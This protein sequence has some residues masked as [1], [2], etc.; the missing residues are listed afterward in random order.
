GIG[1]FIK[2]SVQ[3]NVEVGDPT[4][5]AVRVDGR[6]VRA[7]VIGEGA[8]LGCTQAGRIEYALS[9]GGATGGSINTDFIDN[10]AGAA[11]P[12]HEVN[13]KIALAAA[14]RAGRLTEPARIKL[15][16]AMTEEVA[17]DVLENNRL[18]A[19]ALSIAEARGPTAIG[20][21]LRLIETLEESGQLDRKTEGL[22]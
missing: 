10:S 13:I 5:D 22:A 19:L 9:G 6:A 4:N 2:S 12:A 11:C 8:N 1:T 17:A 20:A 16:E 18:Q 3:N 21:Q 15:L 7:K 14:K